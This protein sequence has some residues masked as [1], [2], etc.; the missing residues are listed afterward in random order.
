MNVLEDPASCAA[1]LGLLHWKGRWVPGQG[2]ACQ[3]P[4][5]TVQRGHV[6][7]T[8]D[9]ELSEGRKE[10]SAQSKGLNIKG[11]NS[12]AETA[13]P[14]PVWAPAM[15]QPPGG[16]AAWLQGARGQMAWSAAGGADSHAA[17]QPI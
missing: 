6:D 9:R 1:R 10:G 5:R 7:N 4:L 15:G 17:G 13:A 3:L 11:T 8:Q 14:Q 16:H 12:V 2:C